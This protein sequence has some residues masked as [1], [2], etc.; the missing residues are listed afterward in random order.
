LARRLD[1]PEVAIGFE[2]SMPGD[3]RARVQRFDLIECAQPVEA[4]LFVRLRQVEMSTV[5]DGI[6]GDDQIDGRNMQAC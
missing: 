1:M 3:H 4:A 6:P 5:I 2:H